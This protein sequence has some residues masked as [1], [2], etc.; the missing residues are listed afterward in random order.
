[1]ERISYEERNAAE[2]ELLW[3]YAGRRVRAGS[4]PARAGEP[5]EGFSAA[6][7]ALERQGKLSG[8]QRASVV[9]R[10]GK[11]GRL[12]L[13]GAC[14]GVLAHAA[15]ED[16]RLELASR[17]GTEGARTS[18]LARPGVPM[19]LGALER[20]SEAG[21]RGLFRAASG[22]ESARMLLILTVKTGGRP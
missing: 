19:L 15:G 22:G 6:L 4:G 3:G 14:L 16:V 21:A 17:L 5:G 18:V 10:D 1:V 7:R 9:V 12:D 20:S 2:V 8:R 11:E 13:P